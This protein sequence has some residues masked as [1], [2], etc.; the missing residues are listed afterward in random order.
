M[1]KPFSDFG[2]LRSLRK[3]LE[4]KEAVASGKLNPPTQQ[5]RSSKTV[6]LKSREEEHARNIGIEKGHKIRMMDTNDSGTII[7]FG[8]D[9][10][11]IE[12]D[13]LPMRAVRSEFVLVDDE[14][15]R[16]MLS[17]MPSKPKKHQNSAQSQSGSA[18][19]TVIDLHMDRIPGYERVPEWAAL[20]Y[21]LGYFRQVIRENQK[22]RGKKLI[23]IHGDGD[24]TLR[25]AI[26]KELDEV[27]ALTCSYS[28]ASPDIYGTGATAVTIR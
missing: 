20:D 6:I 17:A 3:D 1:S 22:H 15:D 9:Y 28:P 16:K 7:G 13:G 19:E 11:E 14:E 24:G 18:G 21:Q 25:N 8:K 4:Q 27:F 5:K 26:R 2:A 12:I 23:F 10:Y